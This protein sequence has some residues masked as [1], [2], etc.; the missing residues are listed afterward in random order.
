MYI[1]ARQYSLIAPLLGDQSPLDLSLIGRTAA[2]ISSPGK[3]KRPLRKSLPDTMFK[4]P[5]HS[6]LT[7]LRAWVRENK[8]SE[9]E[10]N[11]RQFWNFSQMQ[12]VAEKLWA[13][14]MGRMIRVPDMPI[15]VQMHLGVFDKSGLGAI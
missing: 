15:Q 4:D 12:P 6:W 7:I 11:E 14:F 1:D 3:R 10:V 5:E 9:I 2:E 13:T 8:V